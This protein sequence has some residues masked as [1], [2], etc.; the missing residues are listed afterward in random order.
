MKQLLFIISFLVIS[1]TTATAQT[2]KLQV[3]V[4]EKT[5]LITTIQLLSGYRY[6]TTADIA[7]KKEVLAHFKRFQGHEAVKLYKTISTWFYGGA[8]LAFIAHY[9][10]PKTK[11]IA[12]FTAEDE[13]TFS[14]KTKKDTLNLFL[15]LLVDFYKTSDFHTFFK[16]QQP[17]YAQISD[18]ILKESKRVDYIGI[19]EKHFGQQQFAYKVILSPLQMDAGF[20][21]MLETAHGN[22]LYSFIGPKYDSKDI[23]DFDSEI[24]FQE[25][26]LHEFS[27]SFCNPLIDKNMKVLNADS[28]LLLPILKDQLDQGYGTWQTCLLE[29]W[30]RANEIVLNRII[31]GQPIADT[32]LAKNIDEEKWIYLKG[33]VDILE[34][35]YV[36]NRTQHRTLESIMPKVIVYFEKESRNCR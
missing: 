13:L 21:P 20:G 24:L 7:Y 14:Y 34:K 32:L 4:D 27:H 2:R 6:L 18:A 10:F 11:A 9:D 28:C 31:Y 25:L 5:E 36:T 3:Y 30:T 23:P 1:Q 19:M 15:N 8:P 12:R 35:E 26:I 16:S 33:L 17:F 22:I 29:H